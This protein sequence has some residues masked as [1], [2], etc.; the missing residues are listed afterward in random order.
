MLPER[1]AQLALAV[2]LVP[3]VLVLYLAAVEGAVRV[4]PSRRQG[5]VRPWLWIGPAIV[6]VAVFLVIPA[7]NTAYLSLL[8]SDSTAF[9]GAD[10]YRYAASDPGLLSAIQN[11][12]VW[13]I[14]LPLL[15]VTAG[16]AMAVLTDRV[17]YGRAARSILFLPIAIS[18]VAAGVIW[19]FMYDYR[20]PGA[21]QTGTL[22]GLLT[23]LIPGAEPQ[24]WLINSLTNNG[25]LIVATVWMQAG[26]CMIVL[27]AGLK[28]IPDELLEAARVDG[29]NEWQLF[30]RITLPL[31]MPTVTVVATTMAI[32]ALKA[33]DIVY[34]MTNGNFDT[35]VIATRMF[36]ELFSARHY[37][38][39]SAIAVILMAAVVPIMIWNLRSFRQQQAG[40][41]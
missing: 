23:G 6:L 40:G 7:I 17:P 18:A 5:Q 22:N 27:A 31:L 9:V 2:L 29:A 8:N 28:G 16:L 12:L 21:A 13:L 24:T 39:A 33:F 14:S 11:S 15:A 19:R 32:I 37:G 35:D 4:L 25:A 20:P 10:N 38:R 34:V 41:R 26:F 3:A 30:R 36:K 1:A